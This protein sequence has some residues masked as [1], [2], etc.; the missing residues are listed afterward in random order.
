MRVYTA[1]ISEDPEDGGYL[2]DF[3]SLPGCHTYGRTLDEAQSNAKDALE[4]FI[5]ALTKIG[6]V[7]PDEGF[8]AAMQ[9]KAVAG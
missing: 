6:A 4:G 3:P 9:V 8:V 2:V 1:I 5:E 7:L